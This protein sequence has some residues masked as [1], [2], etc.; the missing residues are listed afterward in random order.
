MRKRC[1]RR[2]VQALPPRGL[3]P[4]LDRGQRTD[5][6]LAHLVNLDDMVRGDA[7]EELLWQVVEQTLVWSRVADLLQHR[8]DEM[9]AQL[10]MVTSVVQRYGRTGRVGFSGVEYQLAKAGV[11]VMDE[12]AEATDKATAVEAALWADMRV[13]GLQLQSNAGQ[14]ACTGA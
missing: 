12:L 6:A 5:L 13:A 8:T 1:A 9:R 2:P 7:T 11:S 3:R 10:D 14:A 4:R